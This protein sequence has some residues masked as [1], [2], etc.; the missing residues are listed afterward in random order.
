MHTPVDQDRPVDIEQAFIAL[1]EPLDNGLLKMRLGRQQIGFDLQRFVSVRDGPNVRQS[2]D[3]A[4]IDYE[5]GNW[6][7]ITFT[8]IRFRIGTSARS[9]ITATPNSATGFSHRAARD[10]VGLSGRLCLPIHPER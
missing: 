7:Y 5:K 10:A 9:M 4:W 6:R 2:Y 8:V 3:A 1:T